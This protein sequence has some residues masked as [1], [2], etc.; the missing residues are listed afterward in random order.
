MRQIRFLMPEMISGLGQFRGTEWNEDSGER[1]IP[2][3]ARAVTTRIAKMQQGEIFKLYSLISNGA[4]RN[5]ARF[6]RNILS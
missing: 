4:P 5:N 6:G 1:D 2:L 3:I